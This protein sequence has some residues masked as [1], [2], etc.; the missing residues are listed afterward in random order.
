MYEFQRKL[1]VGWEK[2]S[3][4]LQ[5]NKKKP[6]DFIPFKGNVADEYMWS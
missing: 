5:K 3:F 4:F 2:I 1:T 6:A